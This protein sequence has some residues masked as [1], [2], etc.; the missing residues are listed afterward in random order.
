MFVAWDLLKSIKALY[1]HYLFAD[2]QSL[3]HVHSLG[4]HVASPP[5][6][7]AALNARA[8]VES[9]GWN[10]ISGHLYRRIRELHRSEFT[11]VTT[12][13]STDW[14]QNAIKD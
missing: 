14:N 1:T 11:L 13:T 12:Y 6:F 8:E 2:S 5:D 10:P 4:N 7:A 3:F 9:I